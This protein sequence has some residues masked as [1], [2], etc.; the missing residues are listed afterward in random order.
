MN[1]GIDYW[2]VISHY[3]DYFS[4]LIELHSNN[5]D[6]VHVISAI[7]KARIG[8][9]MEEVKVKV[10]L[11]NY[12]DLA[13]I[14]EVVFDSPKQSPELKLAKCQELGIEVFYDDRDDVCRLLNQHGIL[15]MRV[16]RKDNSK[17]DLGAERS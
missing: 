14:H 12:Y 8:T 3:P 13:G 10:G 17:Y 4:R 16:T 2:Q 15:A 6:E 11:A 9:I 7:G 5:G 1:I